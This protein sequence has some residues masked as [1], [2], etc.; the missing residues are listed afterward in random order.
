[1]KP[2]LPAI[3]Y[4]EAIKVLQKEGVVII[5]KTSAGKFQVAGNLSSVKLKIISPPPSR[6]SLSIREYRATVESITTS[7]AQPSLSPPAPG[8][9]RRRSASG[10][11]P[12]PSELWA[13]P[14]TRVHSPGPSPA[15]AINDH[16]MSGSDV[17]RRDHSVTVRLGVHRTASEHCQCD[18]VTPTRRV[19]TIYKYGTSS[20]NIEKFLQLY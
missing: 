6:P 12:S 18:S 19:V 1:V 8:R 14:A 15:I 7:P 10:P 20:K 17:R 5:I 9:G 2:A 3:C 4:L 11:R 16:I 13:R